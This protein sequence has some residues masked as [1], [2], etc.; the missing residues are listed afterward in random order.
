MGDLDDILGE[1]IASLPLEDI[2]LE[3]IPDV[4]LD[5]DLD[6]DIPETELD[7]SDNNSN[8]QESYEHNGNISFGRKMCPSRHGCQ[9]ATD[10]D[11]CLG[12]YPG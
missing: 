1:I 10:C 2:D 9:G 6:L 12:D 4:D 8:T 11:Y 7:L 5:L 3:D